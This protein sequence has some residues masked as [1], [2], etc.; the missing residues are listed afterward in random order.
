VKPWWYHPALEGLTDFVVVLDPADGTILHVNGFVEDLLG[1]PDGEGIGASIADYV[2]PDDLVRAAEVM[3]LMNDEELDVPL[4]PAVYRIRAADGSWTPVELNAAMHRNDDGE[5][6]AVIV[7]RY[8]GDRDLQDQI[9]ERLIDGASPAE[10]IELVPRFGSWRHPDDHYA[11]LYALDD[12]RPVVVGS[13]ES[14]RLIDP[15][16]PQTPWALAAM[17]D[18]EM[19]VAADELPSDLRQ[20]AIDAGLSACWAM[21]VPD[22][23]RAE[24]AVIVAWNRDG[25]G[26]PEVHRYALQTMARA[27]R[28]ILQWRQQVT[29]LRMAARRDPLTGL[30]N[31]TSFFEVLDGLE[32]ARS[33]DLVGV[34][35]IDLD[36]FKAVNDEHGHLIGDD[37]LVEAAN[38]I[39]RVLRP[40]DTV[41]RLGGDEFAVLC[42][43]L[44]GVDD[45]GAIA[46]RIVAAFAEP[47]VIDGRVVSIGASVGIATVRATELDGELLLDSADQALYEAKNAGR[48]RWE[49][50][51]G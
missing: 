29:S 4:T 6:V 48:G 39:A 3:G 14:V 36:G 20:A 24:P 12:G 7:G 8:S 45:A 23:L 46:D 41:A 19:V 37:V 15:E 10:V 13:P 44:G 49:L 11:V 31:R 33:G 28:L 1:V 42:Q 26:S 35:Y 22:P 51:A 40:S 27:L 32:E 50:A 9:L 47:F 30:P 18:E 34:L 38:R 5:E 43:E 25:A 2:H 17:K 16:A 21:P